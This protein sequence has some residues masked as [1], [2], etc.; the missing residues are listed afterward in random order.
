MKFDYVEEK[1]LNLH[2]AFIGKIVAKNGDYK[3]KV[4]PLSLI[5]QYG[6]SPMKQAILTDVPILKN[7]YH[8]ELYE[9]EIDGGAHSQYSGNGVH[10]HGKHGGH[11]RIVPLKVGDIVF[12]MCAERDITET[13]KGNLALPALGHH[14][15]KD[16]VIVGV[17]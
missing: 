1:L 11:V 15:I 12:C 17:L 9:T 5:K 4:Q 3:A 10:T 7:V 13:K 6:K 2:T 14:E 8:L 16:A